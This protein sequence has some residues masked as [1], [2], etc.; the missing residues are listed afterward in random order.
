MPTSSASSKLV[1]QRQPNGAV[2]SDAAIT[3]SVMKMTIADEDSVA[4]S[5]RIWMVAPPDEKALSSASDR[6]MII[7]VVSAAWSWKY[8]DSI[9]I[10]PEKPIATADQR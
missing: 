2:S 8:G 3:I 7:D 9:R 6:P 5:R 10:T 4:V 1:G